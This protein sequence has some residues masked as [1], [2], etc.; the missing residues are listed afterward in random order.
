MNQN[1]PLVSIIMGVYNGEF[2]VKRCIESILMQ[3]YIRWEF[4]ICD[5]CSTDKTYDIIKQYALNDSRIKILKNDHNLR[6]AAT[7]NRCLLESKGKYIARID[8]DDESY[9]DRIARQ[10]KFL[11]ENP[12]FAVVGSNM[13]IFDENGD[14]YIRKYEKNPTKW[15]LITNV[16]FAH[17]TIM[18]RAEVYRELGGYRVG[19][20]TVRAEDLDLWF[21][22]FS[23]GY[24]GYNLDIVLY[25]YHES[26]E[27]YNK[28]SLNSALQTTK[29]FL[30]GYKLI[31]VP[32]YLYI[33]AFKPIVAAIFPKK[34]MYFYHRFF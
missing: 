4:I 33:F 25:R 13:M 34:I 7:L 28:R 31:G 14:K 6:L 12:Q 29:V 16:P 19:D 22:F 9:P 30:K 26:I 24:N 3:T 2:T 1:E 18:M 8:A 17:P 11:N 32:L 21:R 20:D 15:G 10:V 27:D 23:R 5:D